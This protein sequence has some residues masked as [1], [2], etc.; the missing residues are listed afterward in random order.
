M[1]VQDPARVKFQFRIDNSMQRINSI[2]ARLRCA[3]FE[4]RQGTGW[5]KVTGAGVAG[6]A[7]SPGVYLVQ[8]ADETSRC[9]V[10]ESGESF[11]KDPST[12]RLS[13]I[14]EKNESFTFLSLSLSLLEKDLTVQYPRFV[15]EIIKIEEDLR[16]PRSSDERTIVFGIVEKGNK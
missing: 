9:K 5:G 6:L 14:L 12:L 15:R 16:L 13:R 2:Y 11:I 1:G 3:A 7:V 8:V 10:S 4:A